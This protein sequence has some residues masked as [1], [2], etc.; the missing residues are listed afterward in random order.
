MVADFIR[1]TRE[2]V[3]AQRDVLLGY[4]GAPPPHPTVPAAVTAPTELPVTAAAPVQPTS[5]PTSALDTITA[6]IA[7]R[8]G[9]PAEMV[10]PGLDLEADLSIDSI[11]RTEIV[12]ELVSRL[13]SPVPVDDLVRA[14][15]ADELACLLGASGSPAPASADVAGVVTAVIAERTGYPAEMVEPGL[16]LEAD[17]SIDSIKR[18][19]IVGEL[20]ALLGSQVPVDDLVRARTAEELAGLLGGLPAEPSA[21]D[22]SAVI[23]VIADR[24]GYPVEMI[25]PGLDLEADLSID[26]IKRTEIVGELVARLGSS[27]SVD[28]LV[29]ARTADE[30]TALLG[31]ETTPGPAEAEPVAKSSDGVVPTR[32]VLV[33]VPAPDEPTDDPGALFGATILVFGGTSSAA[34]ALA[35]RLSAHGALAVPVPSA[36]ELPEWVER[37]DG[38]VC[39]P[40]D[41]PLLPGG[42]AFI[43]SVL[44]RRPRWLIAI[45]EPAKALGLAGFMRTVRREHPETV[46]RLVELADVPRDDEALVDIAVDELRTPAPNPS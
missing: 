16:D 10:E 29:R 15:T 9:Y 43:K 28:T 20:V 27:V 35:D 36:G 12:G 25:E 19:E 14:R 42:F 11:K 1:S 13:G 30:L 4:L 34:D 40:G 38:L 6:V 41:G 17:L 24:T 5:A 8:T 26:S 18:T 7:E 39:L 21:V 32:Q 31:G 23:A 45:D 33:P 46:A 3:A 44:A 22:S 2:L 37:V